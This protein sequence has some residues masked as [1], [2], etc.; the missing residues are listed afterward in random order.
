MTQRT[1]MPYK[2]PNLIAFV[3]EITKAGVYSI[4]K[5]NRTNVSLAQRYLQA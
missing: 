3:Q 4:S 2:I 1:Q 5:N